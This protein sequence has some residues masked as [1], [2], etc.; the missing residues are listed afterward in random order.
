MLPGGGLLIDTPGMRELQLW[1]AGGL[2]SAFADI[3]ALAD[4]CRFRDCRHRGEPG[5]AV[6]AAVEAGGLPAYRLE[7][8][9]KL[10]AEQEHAEKEQNQRALLDEKR[11]S[12]VASKALRKR[13]KEKR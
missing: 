3:A 5:C 1:D 4:D 11:R 13:L 10:A 8:F 7:S 2:P 12:K 6:A 9:R